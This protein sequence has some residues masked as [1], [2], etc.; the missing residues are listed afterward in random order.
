MSKSQAWTLKLDE[1][2]IA[3]LHLDVPDKGANVLSQAVVKALGKKLDEVEKSDAKG[4]I[5]I[6]DKKA[7]FIAGADVEEFT[8][9]KTAEEAKAVI[10]L[11]HGVFN[12]LEGLNIPTLALIHGHCLG[13]GL[14]LSLACDYRVAEEGASLGFPEVMLGIFPGFGGSVRSI[15]LMGVQHA[16]TMMLT[17]RPVAGKRAKRMGL[18]DAAVPERQMK[19]AAVQVIAQAGSKRVRQTPVLQK[20]INSNVGRKLVAMGLRNMTR[21]RVN[22]KHYPAPFALIDMWARFGNNPKR[23]FQAEIDTV[24]KLLV[25]PQTQNLVRLFFLQDRLKSFGKVAEAK[26]NHIHVIGAG[27]MGGDIAAWCAMQGIKVTLQDQDMQV[28]ARA[29]KRAAALFQKKLREP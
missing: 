23:M 18:V 7:G 28:I 27:V 11:A 14:E 16:M 26:V 10:E 15:G 13:G 6:S 2:H 19:R 5:I 25:L 22:P 21:K 24:S 20:I 9:I 3:W 8:H 1:H 29:I 17:G 4:L 12:H